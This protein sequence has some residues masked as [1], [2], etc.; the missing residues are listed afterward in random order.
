[1][2][3]VLLLVAVG[4]RRPEAR[5]R[6]R[7]RASAVAMVLAALTVL[8]ALLT[9]IPSLGQRSTELFALLVPVHLAIWWALRTPVA[10]SPASAS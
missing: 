3:L 7:R 6:W 8:G 10:R 9:L 2:L 5:G 1:V 4:V